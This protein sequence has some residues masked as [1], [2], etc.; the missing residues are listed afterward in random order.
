MDQRLKSIMCTFIWN[1]PV[2]QESTN[3]NKPTAILT[4]YAPKSKL[5]MC[6][7]YL[8]WFIHIQYS[9]VFVSFLHMVTIIICSYLFPKGLDSLKFYSNHRKNDPGLAWQEDPVDRS[10]SPA[11][12]VRPRRARW[13]NQTWR[14]FRG[15]RKAS[16]GPIFDVETSY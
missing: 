10:R 13:R 6:R 3:E 1:S 8:I 11:K 4:N 12:T 9:L 15:E 14:G 5:Q 2:D 16:N 7:M